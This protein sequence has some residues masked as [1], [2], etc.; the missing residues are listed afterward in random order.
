M[1][2]LTVDFID[3]LQSNDQVRE[4]YMEAQVQTNGEA[5]EGFGVTTQE[6]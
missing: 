5:D 2:S 3:C 6:H 4:S 1:F